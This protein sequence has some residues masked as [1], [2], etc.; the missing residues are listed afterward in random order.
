MGSGMRG[1]A[2][3]EVVGGAEPLG[4]NSLGNHEPVT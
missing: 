1:E 2:R 3:K 4:E